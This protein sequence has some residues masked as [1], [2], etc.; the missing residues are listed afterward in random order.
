MIC[1]RRCREEQMGCK[2][3]CVGV[4]RGAP[5]CGRQFTS[6]ARNETA[7]LTAAPSAV[8]SLSTAVSAYLVVRVK[9]R[10]G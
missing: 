8:V 4:E 5:R 7:R 9:K 2:E 6:H 1:G 10:V 3:R